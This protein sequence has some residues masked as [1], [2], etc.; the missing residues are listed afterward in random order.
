MP[1]R[2]TPRL[3][4]IHQSRGGQ[5]E[6][7]VEAVCDGAT[8]PAIEADIEVATQ[9]ALDGGP[10]DVLTADAVLLATPEHFGYM[11]G[12]MKHFLESIYHPCLE[13]TIGKPW[14]L[15]VNA[16][17]DGTGTVSSVERIVT[18]LRWKKVHPPLVIV[19]HNDA[20]TTPTAATSQSLEAAKDMGRYLAAG[21]DAGLW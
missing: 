14:A 7:L 9:Q 15:L 16:G 20:W 13:L 5:T 1:S 21:L 12:A 19:A 10:E 6:R 8:D 11:S 4:I 3:V 2:R 18:G 17:T